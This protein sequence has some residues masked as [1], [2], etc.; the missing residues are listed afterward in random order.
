MRTLIIEPFLVTCLNPRPYLGTFCNLGT[1]AT[2]PGQLIVVI[3]L[4]ISFGSIH[5]FY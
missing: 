1:N 3:V 4:R 2:L 5:L